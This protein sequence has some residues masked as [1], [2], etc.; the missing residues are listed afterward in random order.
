L[1]W[2]LKE[3]DISVTEEQQFYLKAWSISAEWFGK[4]PFPAIKNQVLSEYRPLI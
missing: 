4:N 3:L 2:L 1:L